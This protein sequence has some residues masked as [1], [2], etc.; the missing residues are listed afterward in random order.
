MGPSES[1][2]SLGGLPW[3]RQVS[4]VVPLGGSSAR[5]RSSSP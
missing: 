1:R 4:W 3:A 5:G 2:E